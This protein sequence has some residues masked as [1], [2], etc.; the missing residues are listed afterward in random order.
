MKAT[1]YKRLDCIRVLAEMKAHLNTEALHSVCVFNL[2]LSLFI[3]VIFGIL[4]QKYTA[5]HFGQTVE[6]LRVL[7]ELRANVE[8]RSIKVKVLW[9]YVELNTCGIPA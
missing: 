3:L 4:S 2:L 5:L 7:I 6:A 9:L 8:A 1:K